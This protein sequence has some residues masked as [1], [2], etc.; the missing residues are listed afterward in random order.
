[1]KNYKYLVLYDC[2]VSNIFFSA[3]SC[4]GA[5]AL[6]EKLK[7]NYFKNP[8][9]RHIFI[10]PDR[11][12]VLTEIKIFE[13]LNI[14]STCTIEVMTLSRLAGKVLEDTKVISK[15]TS[16]M[17]LQK[18]L[19]ENKNL[20]KCFNKKSDSNLASSLF[21]TISQFKSCKIDFDSIVTTNKN[22]LLQDKLHDISLL[23][24]EYQKYLSQNNLLDS[25][26]RL[27]LEIKAINKSEYI[28]NSFVYVSN[29]DSFT[30]QGF[31]VVSELVKSAR[32]FNITFNKPFSVAN[33]HIYNT[34]FIFKFYKILQALGIEPNEFD[35]KSN[36]SEQFNYLQNNLFSFKPNVLKVAQ[37]K[38]HLFEGE[39]F[40]Q[41]LLWACSQ[42]KNLIIEKKYK[43]KDFVVCV[44]NLAK[45]ANLVEQVFN[46]FDFCYFIDVSKDFENSVLFRFIKNIYE[47]VEENFSKR[48]VISLSK[49]SLLAFE[50]SAIQNFE[51]YLNKYNINSKNLFKSSK[52]ENSEKFKDFDEIRKSI[53]NLLNVFESSSLKTFGDYVG[54]FQNILLSVDASQ[55][56]MEKAQ[57]FALNNDASQAKLFEQYYNCLSKIFDEILGVLGSEI[58][59]FKLFYSTLLSGVSST[60]ISTTPLGTNSIFVGDAS[61]SFF[62]KSA[63]YFVLGASENNFPVVLNDCGIISDSEIDALSDS[64][65]LEP[66]V[67]QINHKER[68]KA[69][70]VL[71]KSCGNLFLSYS[72]KDGNASKILQD[73]S[74][75]FVIEDGNGGFNNLGFAK[76][77]DIDFLIKNNNFYVAKSNFIDNFRS[78]L[79]GQ[80]DKQFEAGLLFNLLGFDKEQLKDFSLQ[81]KLKLN[82]SIFFNK[83]TVSVSQ[84]ESYMTC[85]FLH[86][87]RYGLKLKENDEGEFDSLNIG[88]ILHSVGEKFLK[89]NYLPID[90]ENVLKIVKPI[91]DD[92]IKEDV[93]ESLRLKGANDV[94][95]RNLQSEA[96]RFCEA[97][98]YQAK[99]SKFKPTYFEARFD[100][101]NKIKTIKIKTKNKILTL[102]GQVDR[103]DVFEDYFRIID[104]KTGKCDKSFKELFFGKKVQLEAYLKVCESSLKLKP[105]GAYYFPI[106][107]SF[108]GEEIGSNQKYKLKG[109]TILSQNIFEASD[110]KLASEKQSDIIE[111]S[112]NKNDEQERKLS[113][114]SKILSVDDL[115]N[116]MNYAVNIISQACDDIESL[117][118]TP[119]PLVVGDNLCERC[120]FFALCKY[121]EACGNFKRAPLCKIT[122]QNFNQVE[123]ANE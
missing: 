60:K 69:F 101:N 48:S 63:N 34:E 57:Y 28:K 106:K 53:L 45:R 37:N 8:L 74:K 65:K 67:A 102:V 51:D 86:Y 103:I 59:D 14:E 49:N 13:S 83:K 2:M 90:E 4:D 97:L 85:P 12:S 98:N 21:E 121:D 22:Q 54:A 3:T 24:R 80:K 119:N 20:L 95:I 104:Y 108:V 114:Y 92:V 47:V 44:P 25:M 70:E 9:S 113:A 116:M 94:L 40:E 26:D 79:D 39:D 43:F 88:K 111:V 36:C 68:F 105:C 122:E 17:I 61:V 84:V 27:D 56:L 16:C 58:C 82:K 35:V 93:Y 110:S 41:E 7:Q 1:M 32:E 55:K 10:V 52:N 19:S 5:D 89:K 76:Y 29:F 73:I 96:V 64:Y 75:M 118:I 72:L 33:E 117:D 62:D 6:I 31:Q 50:T 23:Y 123:E 120:K 46:R 91:F 78:V 99:F 18:L 38:I 71:L 11:V 87:V 81:N 107:G 15:T 30:F 42:I 66:S 100:Q 109:R 112:Y 77:E 115:Q